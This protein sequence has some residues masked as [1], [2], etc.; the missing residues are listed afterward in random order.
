MTFSSQQRRGQVSRR[1]ALRLSA[2]LAAGMGLA[3][4]GALGQQPENPGKLVGKQSDADWMLEDAR[5]N[6]QVFM[7]TEQ[8]TFR[9]EGDGHSRDLII[10]SVRD[11][12]GSTELRV[13]PRAMRVFRADA[14]RDAFTQQGG[15]H[16][17]FHDQEGR[18]QMKT[19]GALVMIV[20]DF[21]DTVHC[22]TLEYDL[23]C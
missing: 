7:F 8:T 15:F 21:E 18:T 14:G 4:S 1:G 2:G 3:A 17:R 19:P 20:R 5:K 11:L 9:L 10:T 12:H 6:P 13:P 22:Y 23:R 16:W